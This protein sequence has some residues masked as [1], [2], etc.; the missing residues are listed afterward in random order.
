MAKPPFLD[1]FERALVLRTSRAMFLLVAVGAA[2]ALAGGGSAF[3]YSWLPSFR[4][5]DPP[6]PAPPKPPE[7]SLADVL[8]VLD[9]PV[10]DQNAYDNDGAQASNFEAA[11]LS[12]D[13]KADASQEQEFAALATELQGMFDSTRYPWLSET[14]AV[15]A[16]PSWN[17]GCFRWETRTLRKGVVQIV[18]EAEEKADE[19]QRL[20][21]LKALVDIVPTC[22]TED[23][24]FL[25]VGAVLD[26]VG[27]AGQVS[28]DELAAFKG[29][30][31]GP[32]PAAGA[33]GAPAVAT[34]LPQP[35]LEDLINAVLRARKRGAEP[36]L[37]IAWF[38]AAQ[39][40]EA[41][42]AKVDLP[43][44]G[45]TPT[46]IP[47]VPAP[48][49]PTTA[50]TPAAPT[51]PTPAVLGLVASWQA[52]QGTLPALASQRLDG[53][54]AIATAAPAARRAEVVNAYG[55]L[56]RSRSTSAQREYQQAL[57]ARADKIAA[58]NADVAKREGEKADTRIWATSVLG[59]GFAAMASVGLLLALLA[60]ER[61]TRALQDLARALP[62]AD[63]EAP[64][65]PGVAA[66]SAPASQV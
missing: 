33:N 58:L 56:V 22:A 36:E 18:N 10:A 61:N 20:L 45:T 32:T 17:G 66:R 27:A 65:N 12:T 9:A 4:G 8:A 25:L 38:G 30:L 62:P 23:D 3:A 16:Y 44:P 39:S 1:R 47:G 6:E 7:V 34:P 5:S 46:V 19:K 29:M 63:R 24:R 13:D 60:V 21:L 28:P 37:L 64:T 42:F 11:Q 14:H 15:C 26:V 2:F 31:T 59:G 51:G 53:I 54:R 49:A 35:V 40:L 57:A 41:I 48:G 55:D 50:T 52:L 43:T